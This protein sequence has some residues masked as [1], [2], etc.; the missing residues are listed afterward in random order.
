M[1]RELYRA[2]EAG[3]RVDLIVRG[4]CRLRPG[5]ARFSENISLISIIGRFLEHNRIYYFRNNDNP[6]LFMG[7]ADWQRRNLDDRVEAIVEIDQ[8]PLKARLIQTLQIAL[9]DERSAWELQSDGNYLLR[10]SAKRN[11]AK[12]FQEIL[13]DRAKAR[14]ARDDSPWDID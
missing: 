11:S 14:S 8:P 13:M 7:S 6:R 4:H 9:D 1:I 2:S 5:L 12:G 3:V 10:M